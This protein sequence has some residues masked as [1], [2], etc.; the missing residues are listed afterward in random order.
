MQDAALFIL[1]TLVDLYILTF[2]L[3]L[4]LQ[5]ARV[6][7]RNPFCQFILRVTNPLVLPLRRVVP[8]VGPVDSATL[9]ALLALQAALTWGLVQLACLTDP[10]LMQLLALTVLRTLQL[11]LRIFFFAILIHV[12]LSWVSPGGYSPAAALVDAIASPL[13]APFRRFIPMIGGIDLS[14]LFA[15]I[16][17]QALTLLLP[18]RDLVAGLLCRGGGQLL[19]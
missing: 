1:R 17:L 12:V 11:L 3:R 19:M 18:L 14:P 15:L 4:I 6:D 2:A 7:A 13:L 16:L 10:G 8:P 5:W 9:V